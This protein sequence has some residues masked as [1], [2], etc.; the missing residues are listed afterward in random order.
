MNNMNH[1]IYLVNNYICYMERQNFTI[2]H[3]KVLFLQK[4]IEKLRKKI[5]IFIVYY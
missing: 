3:Q 5:T 1:G 4:N 2:L